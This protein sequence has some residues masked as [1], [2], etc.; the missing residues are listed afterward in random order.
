[1]KEI[2]L[3]R[4]GR[5]LGAREAGVASDAERPLSPAGEEEVR[6]ALEHLRASGFSPDR[7]ISSPFARAERTAELATVVFPLALRET[8]GVI[9]EGPAQALIE[10]F[11]DAAESSAVLAVGHQPLLGYAAGFLLASPPPDLSTAGFIRIRPGEAGG[12]GTLVELYAPP[13]R[14]GSPR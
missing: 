4:H 6:S 12:A 13:G 9:S 2:V 7:I 8:A 14:E 1:M 11:S 3:L 5:A 10:L